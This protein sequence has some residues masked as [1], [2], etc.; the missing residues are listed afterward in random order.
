MVAAQDMSNDLDLIG[1]MMGTDKSST[2][3][4]YLV[5]DEGQFRD[6][7]RLAFNFIEISADINEILA[8]APCPKRY[9]V[10]YAGHPSELMVRKTCQQYQMSRCG[11]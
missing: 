11:Y 7:R 8:R 6:L 10:A 2:G 9:Q 1:A 4:N 3:Y 5:H